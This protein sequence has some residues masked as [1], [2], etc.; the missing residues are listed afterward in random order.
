MMQAR[1]EKERFRS[2]YT[3]LPIGLSPYK[4]PPHT[5]RIEV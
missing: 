1:H 2:Y 5:K 4:A 3:E